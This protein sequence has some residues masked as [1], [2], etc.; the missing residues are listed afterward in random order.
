MIHQDRPVNTKVAQ[1]ENRLAPLRT[2][3]KSFQSIFKYSAPVPLIAGTCSILPSSL[4]WQYLRTY[5][6]TWARIAAVPR[7]RTPSHR[8]ASR[9][10]HRDRA[11]RRPA[12]PATTTTPASARMF[13]RH[14]L[15]PSG[16]ISFS[17]VSFACSDPSAGKRAPGQATETECDESSSDLVHFPGVAP[18]QVASS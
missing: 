3:R 18:V 17:V 15:A 12:A 6:Y 7:T 14:T 11:D 1:F 5:Q 4:R 13:R 2:R 10:T 9:R 8:T 16:S